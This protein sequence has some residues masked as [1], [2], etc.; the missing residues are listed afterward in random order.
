MNHHY[1][2]SP[3]FSC[4]NNHISVENLEKLA[5]NYINR[6]TYNYLRFKLSEISEL[7]NTEV[8]LK[9]K[10]KLFARLVPQAKA[11]QR[12]P[13]WLMLAWTLSV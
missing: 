10:L 12:F 6:N 4:E 13:K 8:T 5:L 3:V 9:E 1:T 11:K 2:V 7:K